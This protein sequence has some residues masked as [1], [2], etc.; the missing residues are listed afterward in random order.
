MVE[1]FTINNSTATYDFSKNFKSYDDF[2]ERAR[3]VLFTR[4]INKNVEYFTNQGNGV[5][6]KNIRI[7][8]TDTTI[9]AKLAVDGSNY[10][11]N[12]ICF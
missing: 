6:T 12:M 4:D 2:I 11:I 8:H 5:E 1:K 7:S 9:T 3:W 10:R